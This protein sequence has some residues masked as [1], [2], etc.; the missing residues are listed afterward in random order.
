[1]STAPIVPPP[2]PPPLVDAHQRI[3]K[4]RRDY[5]RAP[6]EATWKALNAVRLELAARRWRGER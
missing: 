3:V 1:M 2:A 5:H 4:A 6:S